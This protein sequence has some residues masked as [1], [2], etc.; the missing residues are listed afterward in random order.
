M[1]LAGVHAPRLVGHLGDKVLNRFSM[2]AMVRVC[3]YHDPPLLKLSVH[4]VGCTSRNKYLLHHSWKTH[5]QS[6]PH[7]RPGAHRRKARRSAAS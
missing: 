6:W 7:T 1:L 3:N 5:P 4:I 2:T